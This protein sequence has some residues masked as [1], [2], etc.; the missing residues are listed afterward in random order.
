[1]RLFR[2]PRKAVGWWRTPWQQGAT[3]TTVALGGYFQLTEVPRREDLICLEPPVTRT[4]DECT[5][6][7]ALQRH[8]SMCVIPNPRATEL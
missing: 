6:K 1:M 5:F 3:A 4:H 2:K 8:L 7:N